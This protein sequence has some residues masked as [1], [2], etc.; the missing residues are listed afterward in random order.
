MIGDIENAFRRAFLTSA[1]VAVIA[2]TLKGI[3]GLDH[4]APGTS[5][6]VVSENYEYPVGHWVLLDDFWGFLP[7]DS[8]AGDTTLVE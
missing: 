3:N 7:F 5:I 8:N 2:E 1:D 6:E 4:V